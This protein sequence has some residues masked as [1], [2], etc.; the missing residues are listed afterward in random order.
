V[1][2][3]VRE[4]K[5]LLM[6]AALSLTSLLTTL[7]QLMAEHQGWLLDRAHVM[8]RFRDDHG[9]V[10][11]QN[12]AFELSASSGAAW[13]SITFERR[14][15]SLILR[16]GEFLVKLS[17]S[18][19]S[20]LVKWE[21]TLGLVDHDPVRNLA[22]YLARFKSCV[23]LSATVNPSSVFARSLGL[24]PEM[25][26]TYDA[27]AE[28]LVEVKTAVDT[29]TSTRYKQRT[30]EMYSKIS[31]RLAA[32]I[33]STD[34]GVGIF[35]PSY[36]V[37]APISVMVSKRVSGRLMVSEAPG[38]TNDKVEE[39]FDSFRSSDESV[40]FGV[41]G[42]RFSEGEDFEGGMM[43]SIAVVGL[44][45]P[46]PSPMMHAEYACLKRAG[47]GD[48]YL[49]LSRLPALRKAFQAAGRHVRSPGKRGLVFFFDE[50]FGSQAARDLMPSWLKKDLVVGDMTPNS[51]E[52]LSR[53]FWSSHG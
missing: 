42:G 13:G 51:I 10:W 15:L 53:D 50:R 21:N 5:A 30:P 7:E 48:S 38:L 6:D 32:M 19:R 37:L 2:G 17:T 27:S 14:L 34:A 23:L 16:V 3:A 41:Q 36:S 12:L 1:R 24:T 8:E 20:V 46:P 52:S 45:L 43:G 44:A 22:D 47:E 4:A 18:S 11:L 33:K 29:G 31:D 40:L 28:S 35:A 26:K 39:L 25:V 9:T 49:M